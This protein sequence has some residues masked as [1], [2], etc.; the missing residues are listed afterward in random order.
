M[1]TAGAPVRQACAVARSIEAEL[2]FAVGGGRTVLTRQRV[3]YPFHVTRPFHLDRL[4]PD[5]ATLYLQSA[6]GGLYRGDRIALTLDV[7]TGAAV[8]V[9]TQASTIVH[10]TGGFGVEQA[11]R[12]TVGPDAFAV[13]TPD[14]LVLFPGAAIE[15]RTEIALDATARA[16]LTDGFCHH[17][18]GAQDHAFDCCALSTIV[19]DAQGHVLVADRGVIDGATF[20]SRFSPLGR[21]RAVGTL[22]ALGPGADRL[23]PATLEHC[24]DGLGCLAGMSPAPNRAGAAIRILAPDGGTLVRGLDAAFALAFEA[25]VGVAPARR[26][27]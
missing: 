27:K 8:H 10:D 5:L 16:I 14:P 26:R 11:T 6:S 7:M 18:P 23:D 19:R 20:G 9:T 1:R 22:L 4:R 25:L 13:F 2:C 12:I 21:H 24:L 15:S 17:D 3:P